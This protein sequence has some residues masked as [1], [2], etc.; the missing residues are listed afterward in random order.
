MASSRILTALSSCITP[1][2]LSTSIL[3]Q[4]AIPL[5]V[6]SQFDMQKCVN[7]GNSLE[8]PTE[9]DWGPPIDLAHFSLIKQAGFDTVRIPVRWSAHTGGAPEYKI[10][11]IFMARVD[12]VVSTALA[13]NLNVILNI[14]HFEEIMA[15]PKGEL[16]KL[17]AMWR[18]IGIQFSDAPDDLWF[19]ALNEPFENLKGPIMQA[20]Q[21]ASTM[22][23]RESN[24]TRIIIL[25]GEDWSGIRTLATNIAPPDDN[26]VYTF[27]Y[28]DPFNFTH[29]KAP[30]LGKDMPKKKRS[31]GNSED[32][33]ELD[34]AV[35]TATD[36][37]SLVGRPIFMGEFGAYQGIK[38][39]DRVKWVGAVRKEMEVGN[40]PWCLWSFSNT[41]AL[42]DADRKSWDQD[43]LD[44][45]G[46]KHP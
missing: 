18:Q 8:A 33:N 26:I 46:Q 15:A 36:F 17:V 21:K 31:W 30:W 3:A 25:G 16:R 32:H 14:H 24:P 41:F 45:L 2:C 7:V 37:R 11:P 38:N 27:H 13:N 4:T 39:K 20:A 29:Q 5:S 23:I 22:A 35:K 1:L 44:A 9:G 19:E 34:A 42:Y 12:S 28:Y 6:S 40:I 43:M 10:D